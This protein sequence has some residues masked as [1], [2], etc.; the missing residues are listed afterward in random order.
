MQI[1]KGA[2]N[3]PL[4][5][6]CEVTSNPAANITWYR[7]R[8]NRVYVEH[9]RSTLE[10]DYRRRTV[11]LLSPVSR[12]VKSIRERLGLFNTDRVNGDLYEDEAV[13]NG[14][15][16]TI[17]SFNC[18][19]LVRTSLVVT[20]N[21]TNYNLERYKRDVH[22]DATSRETLYTDSKETVQFTSQDSD[23]GISLFFHSDFLIFIFEKLFSL[24]FFK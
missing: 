12:D 18:A 16:Y 21:T 8:L 6:N 17:A 10:H 5:L 15:T 20:K 1:D 2:C 11:R 23:T 7:R 14:P 3:K 4:T 9:L 19:N 24:F 13:G 22:T